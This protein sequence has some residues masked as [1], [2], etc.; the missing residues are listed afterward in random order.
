GWLTALVVFATCWWI[1]RRSLYLSAMVVLFLVT[2]A[3]VWW[4]WHLI[5]IGWL[6]V[7]ALMGALLVSTIRWKDR[8]E[9]RGQWLGPSSEAEDESPTAAADAKEFSVS[10]PARGMILFAILSWS[11][12]TTSA[13]ETASPPREATPTPSASA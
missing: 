7:P 11:M 1:A 13:Q 6:L 10:T 9:R 12:T 3:S 5:T 4:P 8:V 2:L